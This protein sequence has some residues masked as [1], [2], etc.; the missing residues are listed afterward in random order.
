MHTIASIIRNDK[1]L[2]AGDL[3][4]YFRKFMQNARNLGNAY[5]N[6]RHILHVVYLCH[7]A[8]EYYRDTFSLRERRHL[9]IAALYHDYNHP[10][11]AGNDDLNIQFALR[12]LEQHIQPEDRFAL[13][14]IS[15]IISATEFPYTRP[16]TELSLACLILRDADA[17][18]AMSVAWIQQVVFGL[19]AEMGVCWQQVLRMQEGF[20]AGLKF[21]SSWA[22]EKF[23]PDMIAAKIAEAKELIDLL[24]GE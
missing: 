12:G 9:L 22:R 7:D 5:H 23:P 16:F 18:Q 10:G 3:R 1:G 11:R 20:H 13:D 17:A 15:D 2:Y 24:I 4:H 14:K 21:H 6:F 8:C 19:G